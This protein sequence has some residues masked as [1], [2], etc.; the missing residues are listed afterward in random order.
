M[1]VH[2]ATFF[3]S[4]AIP[5]GTPGVYGAV[6]TQ[7]TCSAQAFFAQFS[8]STVMYNASLAVYYVLV[9]VKKK[10]DNE[11]ARVEPWMHANAIAWGLGTGIAG[12]G[13][14]VRRILYPLC[15]MVYSR[16]M[17]NSLSC[18]CIIFCSSSTK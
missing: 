16:L 6:G 5:R 10:K 2:H 11:I 17:I 8:L 18:L 4:S 3:L 1:I 15:G 12:L 7:Q 13:L 9:I 14:T